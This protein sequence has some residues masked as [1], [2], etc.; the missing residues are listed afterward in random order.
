MGFVS[1]FL[2]NAERLMAAAGNAPGSDDTDLAVLVRQDGSV[3]VVM[4]AGWQAESAAAH[5]GAQTVYRIRRTQGN[6][7]VEGHSGADRCVLESH[8]GAL[9]ARQLLGGLPRYLTA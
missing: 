7:R 4:E 9:I 3:H 1:L 8:S 2:S 6:V 5:Y